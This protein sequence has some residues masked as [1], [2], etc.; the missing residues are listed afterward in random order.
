MKTGQ[1]KKPKKGGKAILK[2]EAKNI[3]FVLD[4]PGAKEVFL[5]GEFNR[6]DIRSLPM[7]K[8]KDGIWRTKI[9]L[10][11]GC[12]EYKLFVDNA[13]IEDLPDKERVPNP[14][15]TQNFVIRVD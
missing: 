12:Y 15:G 7:K 11:P 8:G 14:F 1:E 10:F 3:E 13:W 5:A 4:A 6:W 9:K 2:K